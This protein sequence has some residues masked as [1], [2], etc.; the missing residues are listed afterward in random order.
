MINFQLVPRLGVFC[1]LL[2]GIG[3]A[4]VAC[5]DGNQQVYG[6][7]NHQ[8]DT[9]A[10]YFNEM[11]RHGSSKNIS[12]LSAYESKVRGSLFEMYPSYWQLNG[13]LTSQ[14]AEQILA[15][16]H[17]YRGSV[18]AE[19]LVADYAEQ[20]AMQGDYRSVQAVANAIENADDSEACAVALGFNQTQAGSLRALSEK[21]NVWL[22]TKKMPVLCDRLA[23]EMMR[24]PRITQ[25]D[26]HER[27]IRMMRIDRRKSG[28]QQIDK[29]Q[30][31][32]D[33]AWQLNLPID[34]G[35]IDSI[36]RNPQNFLSTFHAGAYSQLNQYLYVYAISQLAHKSHYEALIRLEDDIRQDNQ[37]SGRLLSEMAR[38]YAYRSIAVKRMNMNTDLGFDSNVL[39]WFQNSLGE[40][41]NFEEAEDYAQAAIYFGQWQ[42]VHRA[43]GLM[44][45]IY[46]RERIWQYWLARSYENLGNQA[47]ARTIY[48]NLASSDIDYYGLLAR[49]RLGWQLSLQ[50]IG[51]NQ[52]P[53]IG[54]N[55]QALVM[56]DVH[57]ARA[58][59]LMQNGAKSSYADREWNWAVK[60]A[61]DSNNA[62]LTLL[63]AKIAQDLGN[64]P[65]SIYAIDNS[66]NLKNA[67]LSHPM[68]YRDEVV[69]HSRHVGI[70]P[71]WVYG[72]IRQES[73]FQTAAQSS[74]QAQG[75]MQII[76]STAR[77]IA[78]G[79][80][81]SVGNMNHPATNIRYG[82][83]YMAD[84]VKKAG[85][86]L[87]VVTAGYNAGPKNAAMWR[88]THGSISADQYVEA[89]PFV[90][91]R[92]YVKNVMTNATI[93][94]VLLG[95]YM[96][97][98][99]RMGTVTAR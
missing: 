26:R 57:Y 24:N 36:R 56:G 85:G 30:Q 54:A 93:Y 44:S 60:K 91:T 63:A 62:H 98:S 2:F 16:V 14:S 81:E 4:G 1:G 8:H 59:L 97:I 13:A 78:K 38:R 20:K 42:D 19:K 25:I 9:G 49:D 52:A 10:T 80:G 96:P 84:N 34:M 31:I 15:F 76:P 45:P 82:T 79:L 86:N 50:D 74:A 89:I 75:L 92:P 69:R 18:M 3:F 23:D 66:P 35:M 40:P 51:G 77:L 12:T 33:L 5:A 29:S 71:A 83:W 99:Q 11:E 68:P 64:Y 65:R 55:E 87:A 41:F 7:T 67:A 88:P 39:V 61:R 21:A 17:R 72:I 47:A 6:T 43:I 27:L 90:E 37:R 46:Q 22:N 48:Q 32:F 95:S 94:G 58:I 53:T 70:D 28:N 73:R